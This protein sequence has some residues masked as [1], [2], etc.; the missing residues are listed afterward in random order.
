MIMLNKKQ[1]LLCAVPLD[2]ECIVTNLL[3]T[4]KQRRRMLDFGITTGT[5]IKPV[6]KCPFGN[7]R[8]Y[9]IKGTLIALRKEDCEKIIVRVCS[10]K[11]Y[12]NS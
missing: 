10:K 1:E 11:V 5:K 6:L 8:A 4:G 12:H 7:L 3:S 9:E 2:T